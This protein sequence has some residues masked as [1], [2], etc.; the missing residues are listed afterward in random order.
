MKNR[1]KVLQLTILIFF[2]FLTASETQAQSNNDITGIWMA[3]GYGRVIQVD[4]ASVRIYDL[5]EISCTAN[6]EYPLAM[7]ADALSVSG[8]KL[9]FKR[10]VTQYT[11]DKIPELP[12]LCNQKLTKKERKSPLYNFDVLWNTF[13]EHYAYFKER[14]I[15]WPQMQEKYR[16][17][18]TDKTSQSELF[19][20][21]DAMLEELNDGHVGIEASKKL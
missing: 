9:T 3:R 14:N 15:D 12:N 17:K 2:S 20:I 13:N 5:A 6:V 7:F 11:F 18:L 4:A 19:A 21:C 16:S 10:G 1:T 8:D